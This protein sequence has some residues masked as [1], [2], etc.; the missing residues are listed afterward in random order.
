[1]YE[2]QFLLHRLSLQVIPPN[3][4]KGW[5]IGKKNIFFSFTQPLAK[6]KGIALKQKV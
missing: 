5:V 3:F 4:L 6:T 2:R 1:M